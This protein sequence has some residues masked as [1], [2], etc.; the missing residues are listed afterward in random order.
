MGKDRFTN[1]V[2]DEQH[3]S[4]SYV[5]GDRNENLKTKHTHTHTVRHIAKNCFT[6][7]IVDKWRESSSWINADR[8]EATEN[9]KRIK[10]DSWMGRT[11]WVCIVF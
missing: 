1:M 7:R 9:L 11:D 3:A 8:I 5:D 2:V 4:S 6:D 10:T